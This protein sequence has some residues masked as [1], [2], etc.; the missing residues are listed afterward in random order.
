LIGLAPEGR[1]SLTGALEEGT[2]GAAYLALKSGAP[3]TP[4]TF[5]GTENARVYGNLKRLRRTSITMTVG[6]SF[7]LDR[8]DGWR[9][10]I[11]N[12]TQRIMQALSSQLPPDYR[13]VYAGREQEDGSG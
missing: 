5:T 11:E 3:V 13:G 12:G 6:P 7:Y 8:E 4:V 2:G 1:E 9:Q 10:A